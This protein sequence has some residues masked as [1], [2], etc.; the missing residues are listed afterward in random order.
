MQSEKVVLKNQATQTYEEDFKQSYNLQQQ[1]NENEKEKVIP[2]T[3][4]NSVKSKTPL[5]VPA[6]N[7]TASP[8]K[9]IKSE[10]SSTAKEKQ[11]GNYQSPTIIFNRGKIE[12]KRDN[13]IYSNLQFS[14][15]SQFNVNDNSAWTNYELPSSNDRINKLFSSPPAKVKL[16][17]SPPAPNTDVIMN[18]LH[19]QHQKTDVEPSESTDSTPEWAAPENLG[20]CKPSPP[21]DPIIFTNLFGNRRSPPPNNNRFNPQNHACNPKLQQ[22]QHHQSPK[23]HQNRKQHNDTQHQKV[24][25]RRYRKNDLSRRHQQGHSPTTIRSIIHNHYNEF[26]EK[27]KLLRTPSTEPEPFHSVTVSPDSSAPVTDL[28]M[29]PNPPTEGSYTSNASLELRSPKPPTSLPKPPKLTV[30][31]QKA[32]PTTRCYRCQQLGHYAYDCT[33]ERV[34]ICKICFSTKHRT[35]A[36][37]RNKKNKKK[38]CKHCNSTLHRSY[39]CVLNVSDSSLTEENKQKFRQNLPV[40]KSESPNLPYESDSSRTITDPPNSPNERSRDVPTTAYFHS[41]TPDY[42]KSISPRSQAR[43]WNSNLSKSPKKHKKQRRKHKQKRKQKP[44]K[45]KFPRKRITKFRPKI[46]NQ[47]KEFHQ[48]QQGEKSPYESPMVKTSNNDKMEIEDTEVNQN[49]QSDTTSP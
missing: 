22:N 43:F 32:T 6:Q 49:D 41:P 19:I 15:N 26:N 45:T 9:S 2:P 33:N 4:P 40:L 3:P 21:K 11:K 42:S 18:D 1:Q 13:N 10:R 30:L 7:P 47:Q 14:G 39:D 20:T 17:P 5:S 28:S 27:R 8:T 16:P 12:I 24:Q 23:V 38:R 37:P 29:Y 44:R 34:K 46:P 25:N 31:N 36:C 35:R 48:H